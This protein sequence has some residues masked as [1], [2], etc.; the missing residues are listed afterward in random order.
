M[1]NIY[2]LPVAYNISNK[3]PYIFCSRLFY[4][5]KVIFK[6][7]NDDDDQDD[8]D[9]YKFIIIIFII[10]ILL[11]IIFFCSY[12]MHILIEGNDNWKDVQMSVA[13]SEGYI[14]C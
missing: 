7:H 4:P 1:Q 11:L 13:A 3:T 9:D 6:I 2:M 14:N 10:I 5:V 8:N 12:F